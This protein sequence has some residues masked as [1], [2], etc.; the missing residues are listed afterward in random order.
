VGVEFDGAAGGAVKAGQAV[1]HRGFAGAVG[2]DQRGDRVAFDRQIHVAERL[3][4]AKVHHQM[5][6]LQDCVAHGATPLRG[7][8]LVRLILI[9]PR[10]RQIIIATIS[11]PN[12]STRYS[13]KLRNSS[14]ATVSTNAASTTPMVDPIP[15]STTIARIN[16]DS[17][18]VNEVGLTN[19]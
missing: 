8:K 1:E 3:D 17:K 14:G 12:N 10:G 18:K 7:A 19:P 9:S 6:N 11:T 5:L 4:A 13:A 15:P 16:A 2:A